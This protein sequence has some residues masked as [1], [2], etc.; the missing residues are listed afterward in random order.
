[1]SDAAAVDPEEAFIASIS[2]CHMLWFLAIAARNKLRVNRY[3]DNAV[4]EMGKN[5][6][7]KMAMTAVRLRP[8]IEWDGAT[9]DESLIDAMHHEAHDKCF[10]ANS[11]LSAVTIEPLR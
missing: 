5:P 7:G 2:S 8:M 3:V 6:A 11:V 1:M 9:P 4:G 10:I